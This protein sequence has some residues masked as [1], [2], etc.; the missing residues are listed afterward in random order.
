MFIEGKHLSIPNCCMC[1][2]AKMAVREIPTKKDKLTIIY[3]FA[4]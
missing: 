3:I 2:A 4:M 1:K